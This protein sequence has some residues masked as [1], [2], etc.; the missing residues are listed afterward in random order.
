MNRKLTQDR[1]Y[2]ALSL[3]ERG[4]VQPTKIAMGINIAYRTYCNWQ[5]RSNRDPNDPAFLVTYAG[6]VM[7]FAKAISLATRLAMIELRGMVIQ[8]SIHGR[9]EVTTDHGQIVWQL[10][11]ATVG[12]T[13][14]EREALGFRADGLKVGTDN[15]PMPVTVHKLAPIKL[16]M[17]ALATAFSEWRESKVSEQNITVAGN[18]GVGIAFRPAATYAGPPPPVLAEPAVPAIEDQ[19]GGDIEVED[20]D[21]EEIAEPVE[22][23][24]P[25]P[26]REPTADEKRFGAMSQA[27]R[28][29][30]ARLKAGSK[31]V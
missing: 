31:I 6:E 1:L 7:S 22:I 8:Y 27:Q 14:S 3:I 20:G 30:L 28:E 26:E 16:Q 9:E 18:V 29:I 19:S 21:F 4:I 15:L 5:V 13:P 25:E 2:A 11:P 23:A 17:R 24:E 10:E 12:W